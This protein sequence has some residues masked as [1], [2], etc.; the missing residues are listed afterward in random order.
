M[1]Q[2]GL[3]ICQHDLGLAQPFVPPPTDEPIADLPNVLLWVE[4][5]NVAIKISG[6]GTLSY[7]GFPY[8]DIWEPV[9]RI[10]DAYGLERCLWGTDW[11]RAVNLL[12]YEQGVEAFRLTDTLSDS[13][14]EIL[15]GG[16]L[17]NIYKWT[18]AADE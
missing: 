13:D 6:A 14:R 2:H 1:G 16:S 10:F 5:D 11:T 9:H 12:T 15:M 4:L 8:L 3:F 7:A 17:A 18:P